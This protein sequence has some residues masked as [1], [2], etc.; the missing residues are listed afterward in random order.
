MRAHH[1]EK[2]NTVLQRLRSG[3]PMAGPNGV[4]RAQDRDGAG[5]KGRK[6]RWSP[7]MSPPRASRRSEVDYNPRRRNTYPSLEEEPY[8]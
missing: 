7:S 1:L 3:D 6:R 5:D 2:S 8:R 4:T